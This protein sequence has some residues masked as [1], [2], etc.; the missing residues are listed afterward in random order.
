M[1]RARSRNESRSVTD[2]KVLQRRFVE[3][4]QT[5]GKVD[6]ADELIADT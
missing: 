1:I 4:F 5:E 2:L 6:V 3:E